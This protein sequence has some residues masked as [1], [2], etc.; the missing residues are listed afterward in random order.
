[1][2]AESGDFPGLFF[3]MELDPIDAHNPYKPLKRTSGNGAELLRSQAD[4][5]CA[6]R[7][8]FPHVPCPQLPLP[9][10]H[11]AGAGSTGHREVEAAVC[12]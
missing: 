12:L 11:R 3:P 9:L 10:T 7:G 1:M 8:P 4:P 6:E 2:S 5:K